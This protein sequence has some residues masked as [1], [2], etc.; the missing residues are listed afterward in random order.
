MLDEKH[1]RKRQLITFCGALVLSSIFGGV[2]YGQRPRDVHLTIDSEERELFTNK[3]TLRE[4]LEEAGYKNLDKA[5]TTVD[6]DDKIKDDMDVEVNTLKKV[7]MVEAGEEKEYETYAATVGEFLNEESINYDQDDIIQPARITQLQGQDT[8]ILDHYDTVTDVKKH[9]VD[10]KTI[11]KNTDK[12]YK[13]Q[14]KVSQAG[15]LGVREVEIET[16]YKNGEK[17][18]TRTIRDEVVKKPVNKVV[19]KGTADRPV[20]NTYSQPATTTNTASANGGAAS[21]TYSL[22]SFMYQGV[23]NWGGYRFTYYSQSVLPGSGLNIP[24]RHVNAGGF[25]SDGD[26]YIVLAGAY[27]NGTVFP[28]PFGYYGKIYDHG[29]SGNTLDVYIR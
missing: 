3:P 25:V 26:G 19:L 14:E 22:S 12:L 27:P 4:A 16:V 2:A 1:S 7:H 23:V 17:Y 10:F 28:T 18:D 13:G 20:N 8:I 9:D 15:K 21:S 5:L 24:G 11:T 6:L 29:P